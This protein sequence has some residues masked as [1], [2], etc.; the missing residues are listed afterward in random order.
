MLGHADYMC[1]WD[2]AC[3]H[4]E[5]PNTVSN[6]LL[7]FPYG[8]F[9]RNYMTANSGKGVL[10]PEKRDVV[11]IKKLRSKVSNPGDL[12][13]DMIAGIFLQRGRF[14]YWTNI[15]DL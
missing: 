1:A 8:S 10:C 3:A 5:F 4:H 12:L 13:L 14:Y 9:D 2:S 15:S 6:E 7:D 11:L